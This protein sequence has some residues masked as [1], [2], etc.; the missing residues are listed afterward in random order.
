MAAAKSPW[1]QV[2]DD[3]EKAYEQWYGAARSDVLARVT[4]GENEGEFAKIVG[5]ANLSPF[6]D[7]S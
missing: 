2:D 3:I 4:I 6:S 5:R 7:F 1:Q